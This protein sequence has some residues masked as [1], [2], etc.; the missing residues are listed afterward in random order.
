MKNPCIA[1]FS[2]PDRGHFQRLLPIIGGLAASGV[3]VHVFSHRSFRAPIEQAGARFVDLFSRHPLDRADSNSQPR[4]CRYVT[5]AAHYADALCEEVRR[6]RPAVIVYGTFTVIGHVV[7]RRLGIP[8]VNVCAGH[9]V[10]P[11]EFLRTLPDDPRVRLDPAC[12]RAAE[13]LRDEYGLAD[14]SPFSFVSTLSPF[15]NVYCEPEEFLRPS[16]REVFAPIAF[17]GSIVRT[18]NGCDERHAARPRPNGDLRVYVCFG[19]IVWRHHAA[20]ALA[21][22]EVIARALSAIERVRALISLGGYDA[23]PATIAA[24]QRPN[25]RVETHVDQW[26]ILRESDVFITHQGLNSTHEAIFHRVPM[27]SHPFFWDQPGL[28]RRCQE[29]GLALPLAPAV[30]APLRDEDVAAAVIEVEK[31]REPM[32][33]RLRT[34]CEWEKRVMAGRGAVLE[35]IRNLESA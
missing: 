20:Q 30:G 15:L 5:Y 8:Y 2:M 34:A 27:I 6:L 35:R 3:A 7:A 9:N 4:S 31:R 18:E 28:A 33:A 13:R 23:S 1:F 16:E 29:Y 24:L 21:A 11:A 25:V 32:Q 14:A 22:L 10:N 12:R 17:F 26:E 19:S